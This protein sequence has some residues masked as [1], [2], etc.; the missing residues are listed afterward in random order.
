MKRMKQFQIW[1]SIGTIVFAGCTFGPKNTLTSSDE[2]RV[3]IQKLEAGSG[4]TA[5]SYIGTIEES[6]SVPLSFLV[7]GTVDKVLA[8]E[9]QSVSKGQLLAVLNSENYQNAYQASVAKYNQA[10]DA[11]KR[12]EPVYKSGSLPEIKFVEI[13]TNLEQARSIASISEKNLKDCKLVAP[14]SGFIGRRSIEPGMSVIPGNAIFDLVKID[15]VHV[16]IPVPEKEI[17][18][19]HKGQDV[20]IRVAALGNV[21][22]DGKITE[23]GVLSNPLSHT[24]MVKADIKNQENQLKPGMVCET[25]IDIPEIENRLIIPLKALQSNENGEK[26]VYVADPGAKKALKKAVV[27]GVLVSNGIVIKSGLSAGDLVIVEG[28][29]KISNHSSIQF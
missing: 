13:Q 14:T 27:P 29:Q 7:T 2:V 8:E 15:K 20:K 6:V 23:I 10:Q 24:Y 25:N 22:F 26:F 28:Y 18:A 9:G 11:Y 5:S 16:K 1:M 19:L 12:L 4:S 21:S 17:S 3:K